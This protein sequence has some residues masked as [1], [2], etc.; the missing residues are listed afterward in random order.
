[1][2]GTDGSSES[3]FTPLSITS[4]E[5]GWRALYMPKGGGQDYEVVPLVG[6]GVF[7]R[8]GGSTGN[9]VAGVVA[10]RTYPDVV[11]YLV[12]AEDRTAATFPFAAYLAPGMPE[13]ADAENAALS[14]RPR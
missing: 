14:S 2:N 6:W 8:S 4:A 10:D 13:P 1:M 11:R 7:A 9:T 12:C 5:Q 3:D